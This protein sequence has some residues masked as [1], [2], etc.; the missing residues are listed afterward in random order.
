MEVAGA[1]LPAHQEGGADLRRRGT[2]GQRRR[3]AAAVGDPSGGQDGDPHGAHDLGDE[4]QRA[5]ERL[6]GRLQEASAVPAG[7]ES[8]GAHEIDAARLQGFRLVDRGGDADHRDPPPARLRRHGL[9]Q[10][11][12]DE[13][14]DGGLYL[15]HG[16]ELPLE[17]LDGGRRGLRERR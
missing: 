15:Q 7:L 8:G 17:I 5:G 3:H 14:E 12:E 1:G 2:Q 9:G 10:Q 6:F 11:A 16:L 4:R 13:A